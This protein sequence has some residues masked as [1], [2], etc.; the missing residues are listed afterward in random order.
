MQRLM[1]LPKAELSYQMYSTSPKRPSDALETG[2]LC[3]SSEQFKNIIKELPVYRPIVRP[4]AS[5][6]STL[7]KVKWD[8]FGCAKADGQAVDIINV[9]T[10]SIFQTLLRRLTT[11]RLHQTRREI[12]EAELA[13][14]SPEDLAKRCAYFKVVNDFLEKDNTT[15]PPE[16]KAHFIREFDLTLLIGSRW[17]ELIDAI[18]SEE[19]L[20]INEYDHLLCFDEEENPAQVIEEGSDAAFRQ[21]K[22]RLVS[23]ELGLKDT[24]LRLS[25]ICNMIIALRRMDGDFEARKVILEE[26]PRRVLAVL[27]KFDLGES[28]EDE[29]RSEENNNVDETSMYCS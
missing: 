1:C 22:E 21:Y 13:N 25:G 14:G 8:S 16:E 26:I 23:S 5:F 4:C 20:L 12:Y 29:S 10:N 18:G 19:V 15:L 6:F 24:C 27:G 2:Q 11:I 3:E 17:N 28:E 7:A 9:E